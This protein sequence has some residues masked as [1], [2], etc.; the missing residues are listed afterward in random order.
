[1]KYLVSV[2]DDK[3]NPGSIDRQ[4]VIS[5]FNER[6]IAAGYWVELRPFQ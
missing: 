1:M 6:L 3:E 5:E 4:P 2:I